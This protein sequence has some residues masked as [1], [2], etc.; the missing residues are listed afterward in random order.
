MPTQMGS[1][2]LPCVSLRTTTGM[3]VTGSIIKPRILTSSSMVPPGD[4]DQVLAGE[5]PRPRAR[6]L[7]LQVLSQK[8]FARRSEIY[9]SIASGASAP[10]ISCGVTR[11]GEDLKRRA[12]QLFIRRA[13]NRALMIVQNGEAAALLR[14]G[15]RVGHRTGGSVGPGRIIERVHAII[16]DAV[17]Q[18][19]SC[20]EVAVALAGKADDDVGSDADGAARSADPLDFF[21]IFV[22]RVGAQHGFQDRR[23]SGLHGKMDM[24]AERGSFVDR[25]HDIAREVIGMRGGESHSPNAVHRRDFAEQF[26]KL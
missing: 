6:D 24:V 14:F 18:R 7:D 19:E 5:A 20:L 22:A 15:N 2:P 8:I 3:L 13:L 11:I 4:S 9:N 23:R 17:E 10:L 16:M 1:T 12:D 21:E 25:L 26:D